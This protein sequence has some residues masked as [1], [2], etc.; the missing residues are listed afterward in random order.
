MRQ[1]GQSL[2]QIRAEY[3]VELKALKQLLTDPQEAN[4]KD[5]RGIRNSD[6]RSV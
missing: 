4:Y 5:C 3:Q 6:R 2:K 1:E